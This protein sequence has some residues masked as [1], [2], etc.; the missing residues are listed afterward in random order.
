[1]DKKKY[2][3]NYM[4][5]YRKKNK[6]KIKQYYKER[7][8]NLINSMTPEQMEEYRKEK[9]LE[10]RYYYD[11]NNGEWHK[12][13]FKEVKKNKKVYR[14]LLD[15]QK[16]ATYKYLRTPKGIFKTFKACSKRLKYDFKITLEEITNKMNKGC[17]KCG[18][19][20]EYLK[21]VDFEKPYYINN[22]DAYCDNCKPNRKGK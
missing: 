20:A 2:I 17:I 6:A 22:L 16:P 13:N 1:M 8:R 12:N 19:T 9:K 3:T 5:E 4:V 10:S 15:S 21:R 7:Y 14:K 11:L 18:N